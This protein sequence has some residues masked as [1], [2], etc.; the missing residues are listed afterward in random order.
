[1]SSD[2]WDQRERQAETDRLMREYETRKRSCFRCGY[3]GRGDDYQ[4]HECTI[5]P[6]DNHVK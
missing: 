3:E 1:M 2:Y 4:H 5:Q 6:K